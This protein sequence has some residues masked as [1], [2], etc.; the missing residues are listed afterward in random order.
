MQNH[1]QKGFANM[2]VLVIL[3][4]T[5]GGAVVY[6]KNFPL[7]KLPAEQPPEQPKTKEA[8]N[9][10]TNNPATESQKDLV[11]TYKNTALGYE[12]SYKKPWRIAEGASKKVD[13]STFLSQIRANVGCMDLGGSLPVD[14][15]VI[16]EIQNCL[17][18]S[19]QLKKI[20]DLHNE[21]LKKWSIENS[22]TILLTRLS[23]EEEKQ[24]LRGS[25]VPAELTPQGSFVFVFPGTTKVDFLAES[26][27]KNGFKKSFYSIKNIGRVYFH[28]FRKAP[29]SWGFVGIPY[30]LSKTIYGGSG[31]QNINIGTTASIESQDEKDF[32]SIVDS[33]HFLG[34]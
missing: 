30:P 10:I 18:K 28:D 15:S 27:T 22:Q 31:I 25:L 5:M 1:H 19:G 14:P 21:Y 16:S 17:E 12:I 6:F 8:K 11:E 29:L 23:P 13:E 33:F 7:E 3:L 4:L 20:N 32:F 26:V 2:I 9:I 24:H 34:K